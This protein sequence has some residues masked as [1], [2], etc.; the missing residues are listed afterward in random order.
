MTSHTAFSQDSLKVVEKIPDQKWGVSAVSVSKLITIAILDKIKIYKK[1]VSANP[2]EFVITSIAINIEK[3]G[4]VNGVYF[5]NNIPTKMAKWY[6]TLSIADEIKKIEPAKLARFANKTL[7]YTVIFTN[8]DSEFIVP[9]SNLMNNIPI[10][11]PDFIVE[12]ETEVVV[13][14][15]QVLTMGIRHVDYH[16]K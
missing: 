4:K 13:L 9:R 1:G 3:G 7:L 6:Q 8:D 15:P 11:W 5:P 12:N 14:K 10:I 2:V 16:H